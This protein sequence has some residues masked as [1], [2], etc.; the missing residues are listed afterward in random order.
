M[1]FAVYFSDF[2]GKEKEFKF[3]LGLQK[4]VEVFPMANVNMLPVIEAGT[5]KMFIIG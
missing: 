3:F 1:C 5:F 2:G 4:Y